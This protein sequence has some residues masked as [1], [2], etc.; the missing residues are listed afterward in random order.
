MFHFLTEICL[1]RFNQ[2]GGIYDHGRHQQQIL[3]EY[4]LDLH[5]VN[6]SQRDIAEHTL[7]SKSFVQKVVARYEK[8]NTSLPAVKKNTSGP[9]RKI[10]SDALEYLEVQKLSKP[11]MYASELR[12]RLLLDGVVARVDLPTAA[13]INK[14]LRRDLLMTKKKLT[15]NKS[16]ASTPATVRLA[17]EY[18]Q[19]ISQ[20]HPTGIHFFD[21]SSVTKTTCNRLYGNSMIGTRAVELQRYAS[22]ATYT[23][24]LLFSLRGV[25]YFNILDG[26][27]NGLQMLNFFEEALEVERPDGSVLLERGDVVVMDNCGCHH[28]HFV[29]PILRDMFTNHGVQLLFQ[30]PYS[31]HLNPCEPVFHQVK[32]FLRQEQKLAVEET[33]IAIGMGL[34]GVTSDNAFNYFR[35]A[36]YV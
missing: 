34:Q 6:F 33:K 14:R 1:L 4:I 5:H 24:N 27:S 18:L 26:P 19:A 20:V 23:L 10:D 35:N 13:Q 8:E 31:P 21:E 9:V 25:D 36:G 30:P 22:N 11:S 16:E 3:R 29:E 28:G 12:N 17:D 7:A 32:E 2:N 15:V